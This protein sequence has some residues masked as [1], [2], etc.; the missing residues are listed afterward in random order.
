M[1]YIIQS[2]VVNKTDREGEHRTEELMIL[3]RTQR[4]ERFLS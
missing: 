2:T 4:Y 1:L 3:P